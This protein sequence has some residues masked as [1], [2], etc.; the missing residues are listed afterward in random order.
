MMN[1]IKK[2]LLFLLISFL[3]YSIFSSIKNTYSANDYQNYSV[4]EFVYYDPVNESVC[5]YTNYWTI[6]NQDTTCYRF[7]VIDTD[8]TID[9]STLKI[10]LDH[11]EYINSFGERYP[12]SKYNDVLDS[13]KIKWKKYNGQIDIIDEDTVASLTNITKENI[14]TG[15]CI[16]YESP[17]K[18]NQLVHSFLSTNTTYVNN[19]KFNSDWGYWTKTSFDDQYAYSVGRLG[20]NCIEAKTGNKGIRPVITV[21]KNK[22]TND[23]PRKE[24]SLNNKSPIFSYTPE[25]NYKYL[26]GFTVANY[27]KDG[28]INNKIVFYGIN[29]SGNS[30]VGN[31]IECDLNQTNNCISKLTDNQTN[32]LGHGNGMTY[33]STIGKVILLGNDAYKKICNYDAINS[34][35]IDEKECI[36]L[37]KAGSG[38]ELNGSWI[39]AITPY[40]YGIGYDED[41]DYYYGLFA[42]KIYVLNNNFYPLYSFDTPSSDV[43]QDL[44]YNNGYIYLAKAK[45]SGS[46]PSEYQL[47]CET[48]AGP[49]STIYVY[50]AKF[51]ADGTP[52]KDFGKLVERIYIPDNLGEIESVSFKT[53]SLGKIKMIIGFSTWE[54]NKDT[55]TPSYEF[56]EI[57]SDIYEPEKIN[58]YIRF[59][60][61][62]SVDDKIVYS[63]QPGTI[64]NDFTNKIDTSGTVSFKDNSDNNLSSDSL[65][66]TGDRML[67]LFSDDSQIY[68]LSVL[69]DVT[70]DGISNLSDIK[71]IANHIVDK[72]LIITDEK[73]YAADINNDT[74]IKMN[75]LL[76]LLK[77]VISK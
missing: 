58:E 51:N 15:K 14:T 42:N 19:E 47:Y 76:Y 3:C 74:L 45:T 25:N 60:D 77:Y 68:T 30:E 22:L 54:K 65:L 48:T 40:Y 34:G 28:L 10:M 7:T 67:V 9:K 18:K 26:Q 35:V 31:L 8:D 50:N 75:D 13:V 62:L 55:I 46:C 33:N 71:F 38:G 39:N 6:Y 63:I 56:Y 2:I 37:P 57:E 5:N 1:K 23:K 53:D 17:Q 49:T 61:S 16:Y 11:D 29:L 43:N 36:S 4:D 41:H 12:Y 27:E 52:S 66:K 44:E 64:V 70:E 32:L 73:K 72:N 59:D 20:W 69:G 24:V 21:E